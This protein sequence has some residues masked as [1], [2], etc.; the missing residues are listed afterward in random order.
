MGWACHV[1]S[2]HRWLEG[3][4]VLAGIGPISESKDSAYNKS[5]RRPS[6]ERDKGEHFS[7]RHESLW[8]HIP[9]HT[10]DDYANKA[11][12]YLLEK[13]TSMLDEFRYPNDLYLLRNPSA[14]RR[15]PFY[16]VVIR[17]FVLLVS[18]ILATPRESIDI[19]TTTNARWQL[20]THLQWRSW[21]RL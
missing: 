4:P 7:I 18:L 13:L 2:C 10:R 3:G 1:S 15:S 6:G 17:H 12:P 21:Q 8:P 11:Q 19:V 9:S 20:S 14:Y 16:V 5:E